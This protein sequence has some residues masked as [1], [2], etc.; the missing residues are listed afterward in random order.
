MVEQTQINWRKHEDKLRKLSGYISER[1]ELH[2]HNQ[3][4][5]PSLLKELTILLYYLEDVIGLKGDYNKEI[6]EKMKFLSSKSPI[7]NHYIILEMLKSYKQRIK[8]DI[9]SDFFSDNKDYGFYRADISE[10]EIYFGFA[11]NASEF[12]TALRNEYGEI[13]LNDPVR[14]VINVSHCKYL[15]VDKK[16]DQNHR[17]Y[18]KKGPCALLHCGI[19]EECPNLENLVRDERDF[20]QEFITGNYT[21]KD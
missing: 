2:E 12:L 19:K 20:F 15:W 8:N 6:E 10:K 9:L 14:D 21:L 1:I 17:C 16:N 13:H 18:L 4:Y 7:T 5:N 11:K 3:A